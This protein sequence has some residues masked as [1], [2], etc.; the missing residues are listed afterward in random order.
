[1]DE[2]TDIYALGVIAVEMLAGDLGIQGPV[3]AKIDEV[4]SKRLRGFSAEYDAVAVVLV[5]ALQENRDA[6]FEPSANF[7]MLCCQYCG[8][9]PF[10]PR[11]RVRCRQV[12]RRRARCR[13]APRQCPPTKRREIA[14]PEFP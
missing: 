14:F 6:R 1:V 2:R 7:R 5:S 13:H 10:C 3:F 11:W 8:S 9:V 12:S 4:V